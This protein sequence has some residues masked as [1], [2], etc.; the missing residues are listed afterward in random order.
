V[1]S[2]PFASNPNIKKSTLPYLLSHPPSCFHVF[3]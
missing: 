1:P 2:L 3:T